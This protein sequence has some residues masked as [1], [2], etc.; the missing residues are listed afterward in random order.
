MPTLLLEG[1]IYPPSNTARIASNILFAVRLLLIGLI[2][3]G[4]D[5]LQRIGINQPPQWYLWMYENK[6]TSVL[7]LIVVGGQI[8]NQLLSTG[9]FEV[10]RNG[11]LVWSKLESGRLPTISEFKGFVEI[12][13]NY[14]L[15]SETMTQLGS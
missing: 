5:I 8:E 4:P 2:L 14:Q 15:N 3:G 10:Y 7:L 6:I 11:E 9:A 12:G 13:I 1:E